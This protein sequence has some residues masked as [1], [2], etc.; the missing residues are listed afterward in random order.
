MLECIISSIATLNYLKCPVF[1]KAVK[2][3]KKIEKYNL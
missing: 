2:E 3:H 1:K